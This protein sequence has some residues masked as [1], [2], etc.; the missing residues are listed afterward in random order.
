MLAVE[1]VT[2]CLLAQIWFTAGWSCRCCW[3]PPPRPPLR[4]QHQHPTWP[5]CG[6]SS[7][8]L[9]LRRPDMTPPQHRTRTRI[10]IRVTIMKICVSLLPL[11]VAV[12]A[13]ATAPRWRPASAL[14]MDMGPYILLLITVT[15][16][17][18]QEQQQEQGQGQGRW[19][20]R[21]A[22]LFHSVFVRTR[23]V[24]MTRRVVMAVQWWAALR[25]Y[26]NCLP[27][28]RPPTS[29]DPMRC[30]V[31]CVAAAAAAALGPAP[32]ARHMTHSCW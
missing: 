9:L 12:T 24:M 25:K 27:P 22:C 21:A 30:Y 32:S 29:T 28:R 6:T 11:L 17:M 1:G 26:R 7:H 3:L 19:H 2:V 18:E 31:T 23:A 14:G 15:L 8:S 4:Q 13:T 16:A 20:T 10:R 5:R